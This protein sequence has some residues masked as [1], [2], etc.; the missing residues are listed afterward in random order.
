MTTPKSRETTFSVHM[1]VRVRHHPQETRSSISDKLA[2][3]IP[4]KLQTVRLN[5]TDVVLNIS[6]VEVE[7]FT[8]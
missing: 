1:R 3:V 7:P 8:V 2:V 6:D 4:I 5:G